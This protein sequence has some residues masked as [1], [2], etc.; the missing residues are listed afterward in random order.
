MKKIKVVLKKFLTKEVILYIIFGIFTTIINFASFYIM[1]KIWGWEKNLS[2]FISITLAVILAYS[3]NKDLV[4]H[5]RAE[6][7]KEKLKEF[8]KFIIGRV[9][10]MVVEFF[11]GFILFQTIIP[12]MISKFIITV[13]VIILN[14]LISKFFAF[15]KI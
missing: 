9:F 13:V 12:E 11:G 6:G 5:S 7:I 15:K 10:T 4:F 3:T 2:N 14:F 1:V 8:F